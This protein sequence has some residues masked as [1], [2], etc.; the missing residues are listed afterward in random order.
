MNNES[1]HPNLKIVKFSGP[2]SRDVP[3]G[4]DELANGIREGKYGNWQECIVLINSATGFY[5]FGTGLTTPSDAA[6]IINSGQAAL[7]RG[8]ADRF[9]RNP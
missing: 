1:D 2:D 9:V 8:M 5:V 4:L 7:A 3:A 6:A